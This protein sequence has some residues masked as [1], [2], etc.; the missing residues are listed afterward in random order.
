MVLILNGALVPEGVKL[1]APPVELSRTAG[2]AVVVTGPVAVYVVT[3][4]PAADVVL[5]PAPGT[6]AA[7]EVVVAVKTV[8]APSTQV[9][10]VPAL[11]QVVACAW[12]L[13]GTN[14]AIAAVETLLS[15]VRRIF[16][17]VI[18]HPLHYYY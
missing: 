11:E 2:A 10:V 18:T 12:A 4:G 13:V 9:I 5:R 8:D 3:N 15:S 17:L 14:N 7:D 1:R 16:V 6:T